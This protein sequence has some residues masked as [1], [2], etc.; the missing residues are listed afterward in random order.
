MQADLRRYDEVRYVDLRK[1]ADLLPSSVVSRLGIRELL[2]ELL[3]SCTR[4]PRREL[5]GQLV[6]SGS[7]EFHCL[8][9]RDAGERIDRI[10]FAA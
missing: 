6:R 5:G 9:N 2:F 10:L 7:L 3:E 1:Q 8:S 4:D